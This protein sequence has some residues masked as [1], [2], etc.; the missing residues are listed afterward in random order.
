MK[1][2]LEGYRV[3]DFG[4]AWAG[5]QA[6]QVLADAGAE[7]IKVETRTRLDG[8][9]MGRPLIQEDAA[10]GDEGKWPDMQPVFHGINRNKLGFTIDLTQPK[11]R[12]IIDRLVKISDIAAYASARIITAF[13][14]C[15]D[16][17]R[18]HFCRLIY[19]VLCWLCGLLCHNSTPQSS[20]V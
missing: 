1:Y 17:Q 14:D 12:E 8:S 19:Q 16:N 2:P 10:G 11:S 6:G 3:L 13:L 20:L 7:V 18:P 5:P 15:L 9:R 4:T